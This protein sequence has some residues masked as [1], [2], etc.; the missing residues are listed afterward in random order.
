V[1]AMFSRKPISQATTETLSTIAG[2]I[3]QGIQ[4]A[5]GETALRRSEAFLAE[6]QR[7]SLTGTF[8][9]RA[10]TDEIMWSEQVYRIFEFD[11]SVPVT[12]ELIGTRVHPEDLP[13]LYEIIDRG[14]GDGS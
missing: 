8:S 9:W 7:L 11:Q 14:R 5:Q 10:A 2:T 1:L 6:G 12:L 3:A 4:R 13:L